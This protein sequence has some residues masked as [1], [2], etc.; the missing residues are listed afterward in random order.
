[1]TSLP[2]NPRHSFS[3]FSGSIKYLNSNDRRHIISFRFFMRVARFNKG[4]VVKCY[5]SAN[6]GG[7]NS[8]D[9]IR[10]DAAP[11]TWQEIRRLPY[12]H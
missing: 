2:T 10:L 12:A 4:A 1:M 5:G 7:I 8:T 6:L 3:G 9:L 11:P